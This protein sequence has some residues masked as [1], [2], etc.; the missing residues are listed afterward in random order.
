MTQ[1]I[2]Q[3]FAK[4]KAAGQAAFVAYMMAGDP[5]RAPSQKFLNALPEAGVDIIELGIPFTDPMADGPVIEEAGIRS[6]Q[7]GTTLTTVL[8]MATEFLLLICPLKR[9]A[10][11]ARPLRRKIS[12]LY[13]WLR[14]QQMPSAY[15]RS[16]QAQKVSSIMSP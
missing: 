10:N 14:R 15:Q 16:S 3:T 13:V 9:T 1:R 6:R 4:R 8:E 12:R 7:A 5:D 2:D 11:S